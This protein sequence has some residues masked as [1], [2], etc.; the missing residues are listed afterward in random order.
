MKTLPI[1]PLFLILLIS[2]QF[3]PVSSDLE[4][5]NLRGKVYK[6]SQVVH[7]TGGECLCPAAE[8]A[9]CN[10]SISVYDKNG[11]LT[12]ITGVDDEGIVALDSRFAYNRYGI[13]TGV[14][15]FK[16]D[17]LMSREVPVIKGAIITGLKI[18]DTD[19]SNNK[20]YEFNYTGDK[21]T[22]ELIKDK[23]GNITATIINEYES[24]QLSKQ[25]EKDASGSS[26][27]VNRFIRNGND[28]ISEMIV[29]LSGDTA[30][31]RITFTYEYDTAGNWIK[32]TQVYKDEIINIV[33][34]EIEYY[35][36]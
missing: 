22:E 32:K 8:K 5:E 24:D 11:N 35:K 34:R 14:E 1:T 6:I 31:Y 10:R 19:G 21:V 26:I 4:K 28:D 12:T 16:G 29:S 17:K 33:T 7:S 30:I 15:R 20:T 18:Y 36:D 3:K 27:S 25:T 13:C 23:S 2:C 9:E